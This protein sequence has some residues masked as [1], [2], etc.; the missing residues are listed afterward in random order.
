MD[1][2]APGRA[3]HSDPRRGP[4]VFALGGAA[5]RA[6]LTDA[7]RVG[8]ATAEVVVQAVPPPPPAFE[9]RL[10]PGFPV[11]LVPAE[12]P[13]TRAKVELGPRLFFYRALSGDGTQAFS[14]CHP[15]ELAVTHRPAP[16]GRS[17]REP[18]PR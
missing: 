13:M 3:G 7:Q 18:P 11:P 8:A 15:Q 9:W 10:P 16:A 14:S 5:G 17:P 12:K 2:E 1:R 4:G 6:R